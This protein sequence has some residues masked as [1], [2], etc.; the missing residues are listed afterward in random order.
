MADQ[1]PFSV[2]PPAPS[3]GETIDNEGPGKVK[4]FFTDPKNIATMLVLASALAQPR[5]GNR[6][7]VAHALRGGVGALAFRGNLDQQIALQEATDREQQGIAESRVAAATTDAAAVAAQ[8]RRTTVGAE[9]A[10]LGIEAEKTLQEERIAAGQFARTPPAGGTFAEKIYLAALKSQADSV[11]AWEA[12]GRPGPRPV[13]EDALRDAAMAE[14]AVI[15]GFG[16]EGDLDDK[17]DDEDGTNGDV[18]QIPKTAVEQLSPSATPTQIREATEIDQRKES[19]ENRSFLAGKIIKGVV[20]DETEAAK[21]R[22]KIPEFK[23]MDTEAT[24]AAARATDAMLLAAIGV[25]EDPATLRKLRIRSFAASP[26]V[27]EQFLSYVR[28]I[29]KEKARAAIAARPS[30]F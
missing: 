11:N 17:V 9:T 18:I 6:T 15:G 2:I 14:A 25:E 29:A 22:E 13:F 27:R 3:I 12:N 21:L 8:N 1:D 7:P 5:R 4:Q 23:G 19:R 28:N 24:I 20:T 16:F 30:G 26:K 10:A